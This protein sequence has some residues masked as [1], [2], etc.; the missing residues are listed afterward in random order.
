MV[1]TRPHFCAFAARAALFA[2][3]SL[4]AAC[5]GTPTTAPTPPPQAATAGAA[6]PTPA[7]AAGV[8]M[9]T[10]V[11]VQA[12]TPD[13]PGSAEGLDAGYFSYPANPTRTVPT[14]P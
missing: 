14:P 9:P 7:P 5:R 10:Y 13:I 4:A 8:K 12:A 2:P 11:P 6:A 1:M 3:L